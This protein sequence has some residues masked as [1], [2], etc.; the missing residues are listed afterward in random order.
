MKTNLLIIGFFFLQ[1]SCASQK[2][3]APQFS[4]VKLGTWTVTNQLKNDG[5]ILIPQWHL[6]PGATPKEN[7]AVP[8]EVNQRAIY[9]QLSSWIS[10][11]TFDAMVA[12]GC[13]G[14]IEAQAEKKFNGYSIDDLRSEL[15]KQ[16][17]IEPIL[18][19]VAFKVDAKFSKDVKVACGDNEKLIAENQLALSNLRGLA[20]FKLRIEQ[21][22]LSKLDRE[23]YIHGAAEVLHLPKGAADSVVVEKLNAEIKKSI[24]EFENAIHRRDENF[25]AETQKLKGIKVLV[26]GS[27][28]I[29]DLQ[30]L[31]LEKNI[32]FSIWTPVGLNDQDAQLVEQLK[33]RL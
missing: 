23:S 3:V 7:A 17:D 10:E 15:R 12:E 14:N 18:A 1:V 13:E 24:A 9:L 28:H 30:I 16:K 29:S 8:Q 22:S 31:L 4:N 33:A 6:S 20:G 5:V 21:L 26:V 27:L 25:V 2:V 11:H 32:P 19:P